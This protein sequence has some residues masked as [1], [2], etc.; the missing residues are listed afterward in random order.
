[1][2]APEW[3]HEWLAA[4]FQPIWE[5]HAKPNASSE[6]QKRIKEMLEKEKVLKELAEADWESNITLDPGTVRQIKDTGRSN[7]G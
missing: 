1:M 7:R 4:I 5:W 6:R 3:M 2:K